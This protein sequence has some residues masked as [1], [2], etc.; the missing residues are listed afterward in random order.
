[1]RLQFAHNTRTKN[2][3]FLQSPIWI[4]FSSTSY[5]YM[6]SFQEI[7]QKIGYIKHSYTITKADSELEQE[8]T[9]L[10]LYKCSCCQYYCD[11][12][13]PFLSLQLLKAPF[14]QLKTSVDIKRLNNY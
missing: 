5:L 4:K 12:N 6:D 9:L 7:L 2:N 14:R 11:K 1:M 10:I 8:S 3:N 13:G